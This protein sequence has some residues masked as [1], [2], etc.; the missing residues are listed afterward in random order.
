LPANITPPKISLGEWLEKAQ[1]LHEEMAAKYEPL[2]Y[3][4]ADIRREVN[5][6]HL[7]NLMDAI[8]LKDLRDD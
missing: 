2:N 8:G 5:E 7:N 1:V 3:S 4:I 6:E